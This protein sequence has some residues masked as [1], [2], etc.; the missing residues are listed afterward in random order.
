MPITEKEL[1]NQLAINKDP[2]WHVQF[3]VVLAMLLQLALPDKF[4][5][6]PRYVLPALEALLVILLSASAKP[7]SIVHSPHFRKFNSVF[8]IVLIGAA[9]LYALLQL[10][11]LL[12][13]GG[14]VSDGRSLIL[15]AVNIFITNII[16]FGMLYWEMDSG[17]PVKRLRRSL[18]ERDFSFPQMQD[19]ELA[20]QNWMPNFIDY[21]YVSATN[22]TAFSPTDTMPLTR[23]AKLLMLLQ[24]LV[25]L[26]TIALVASRAVNILK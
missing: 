20:P 3:T 26:T 17:G 12:L 19:P 11:S 16:V 2:V 6:G 9:N 5:A 8:I 1:L 13:A 23:S 15:S 7:R 24:S 18:R 21:L 10:A 14:K 22:A 4:V 25:S